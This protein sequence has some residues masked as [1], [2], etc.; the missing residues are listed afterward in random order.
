MEVTLLSKIIEI[1]SIYKKYNISFINSI[2]EEIQSKIVDNDLIVIDSNLLK[3]INGLEGNKIIKLEANEQLKSF[4]NLDSVISQILS[5]GFKKN[6]TIF[7]VGG[8]IIQDTCAFISSILFRG[9]S[10]SFFPSTLLA[11]CDSCIGGKTSI[12]FSGFKNQLGNFYPPDSI[13]IDLSLLDGLDDSAIRSGVGEML[14]YFL[15]SP[16]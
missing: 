11:M 1:N 14:H 3:F 10:W 8:G 13:F 15:V 2:K 12:N 9:V 5:S 6:N 7:V 16:L 4:E